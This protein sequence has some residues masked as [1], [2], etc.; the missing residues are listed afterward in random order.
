MKYDLPPCVIC[1]EN[2][3]TH[4]ESNERDIWYIVMGLFPL[5][6]PSINF[7]HLLF[8]S[9]PFLPRFSVSLSICSITILR[10][11][12]TLLPSATAYSRSSRVSITAMLMGSSTGIWRF[13]WPQPRLQPRSVLSLYNRWQ[14]SERPSDSPH[15]P[16][17][18]H[19]HTLLF[20]YNLFD[21]IKLKSLIVFSCERRNTILKIIPFLLVEALKALSN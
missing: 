9:F 14:R 4:K 18:L 21:E 16:Y 5:L 3:I 11:S 2:S 1:Q 10:L 15:S 12:I 6:F 20:V 7:P 19:P 17:P 8:S 13:V